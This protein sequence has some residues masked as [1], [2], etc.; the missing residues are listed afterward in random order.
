MIFF[1]E[2]EKKILNYQIQIYLEDINNDF[3]KIINQT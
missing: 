1:N 2:Q 3:E